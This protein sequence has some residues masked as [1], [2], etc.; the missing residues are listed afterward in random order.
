MFRLLQ[1]AML[2]T[3][4]TLINMDGPSLKELANMEGGLGLIAETMKKLFDDQTLIAKRASAIT[5]IQRALGDDLYSALVKFENFPR[6]QA[7]LIDIKDLPLDKLIVEI[8][9]QLSQPKSIDLQVEQKSDQ[10]KKLSNQTLEIKLLECVDRI[11][12]HYKNNNLDIG[13]L[14][15]FIKTA[16]EYPRPN[17]RILQCAVS[18]ILFQVVEPFNIYAASEKMRTH[19]RNVI[20]ALV[21]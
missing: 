18:R 4:E 7:N 21:K 16:A 3:P 10:V 9:T 17:G 8:L 1:N 11:M 13:M 20:R 14:N 12:E 5:N 2:S 19:H 6:E 15:L